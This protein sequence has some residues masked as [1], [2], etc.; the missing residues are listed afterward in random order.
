MERGQTIE[1]ERLRLKPVSISD[2]DAIL[3]LYNTPKFLLYVGDR[4]IRSLTDAEKYIT[5]KFAPQRKNP[6]C[7]NYVVQL[8]EDGSKIGVVGIYA[9]EGLDVSDIG[10]SFLPDSEGKG[11]G[12][13]AASALMAKAFAEFGISKIAA[14][15][16]K[17]NE[18]SQKLITKLGLTFLKTIRLPGDDVDL[19][20]YEKEKL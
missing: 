10:F 9:R 11:Y 17:E 16:V 7:G 13:E 2:A 15:T 6:G 3:A 19:L 14:I 1:T 12:Y 4:K 18:A 8:K 20:Y 5:E